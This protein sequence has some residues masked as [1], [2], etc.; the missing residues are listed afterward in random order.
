MTKATSALHKATGGGAGFASEVRQPVSECMFDDCDDA[1]H[2]CD[3]CALHCFALKGD[4][5]SCP[6]LRPFARSPEWTFRSQL[7][8]QV[9]NRG[10]EVA[11][12]LP[13]DVL[14]G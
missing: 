3:R 7:S 10:D 9:V 6:G 11:H 5:A 14:H 13:A 2:R 12:G 8:G 4:R 1:F